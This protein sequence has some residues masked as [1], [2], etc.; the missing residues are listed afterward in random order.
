MTTLILPKVNGKDSYTEID[1]QASVISAETAC[2]KASF[3][4]AMNVGHLLRATNPRLV[5]DDDLLQWQLDVA[6]TSLQHETP[7]Y[8]GHMFLTAADGSVLQADQLI[9]TLTVQAHAR[10][11]S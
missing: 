6:L 9:E 2:R 4:L 1:V 5:L 10:S 11:A 3:F 8:I 7:Q